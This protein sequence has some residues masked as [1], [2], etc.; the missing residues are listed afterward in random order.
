MF[1]ECA[2]RCP[3]GLPDAFWR[4]RG[5]SGN[6]FRR[7]LSLEN[8]VC[9][10]RFRLMLARE[11][12]VS[13]AVATCTS[14]TLRCEAAPRIVIFFMN[15]LLRMKMSAD[16]PREAA[17]SSR[18]SISGVPFLSW[19]CSW[20]RIRAVILGGLNAVT[21]ITKM[22]PPAEVMRVVGGHSVG[23]QDTNPCCDFGYVACQK[24]SKKYQYL[25]QPNAYLPRR[26]ERSF[27]N[28]VV[29]KNISY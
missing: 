3:G 20:N 4:L 27:L 22:P 14:S 24:A 2:E 26:N 9:N 10:R 15:F 23:R 13:G 12:A 5:P 11:D 21:S 8:F 1:W 16:V 28:F 29:S 25:Q 17:A 6:D 19:I 7:M 18:G